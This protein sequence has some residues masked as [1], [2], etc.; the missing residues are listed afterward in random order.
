MKMIT[1]DMINIY[2][3]EGFDWLNYKIY[4]INEITFHHIKK[5]E[6]DGKYEI[7]NGALLTTRAHRYLN[8]IETYSK[9]I[10]NQINDILREINK[11]GHG[12]TK[13]QSEQIELLLL[14]FECENAKKI[15]HGKYKYNKKKIMAINNR[16][17]EQG[18]MKNKRK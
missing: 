3:V 6:D 16:K 11:N 17:R 18:V 8:L 12:P 15:I 4:D 9:D 14:K 7:E 5:E 2:N 13:R 10:Y 1:K